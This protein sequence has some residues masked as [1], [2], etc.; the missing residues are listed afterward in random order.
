MLLSVNGRSCRGARPEDLP[1]LFDSAVFEA[2][3]AAAATA[4]AAAAAGPA[5]QGG[6]GAGGVR[7]EVL[8]ERHSGGAA[9]AAAAAAGAGR[10][11]LY[12][13]RPRHVHRRV[14]TLPLQQGRD[15][16]IC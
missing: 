9:A 8:S 10:G 12:P 6:P 15:V 3:A 7:V 5:G 13:E 11:P 4:A 2:E 1:V 14:L 16:A